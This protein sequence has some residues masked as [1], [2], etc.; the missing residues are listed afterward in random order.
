AD[1][2]SVAL[3]A[4]MRMELA[5]LRRLL[6]SA[7]WEGDVLHGRAGT[8]EVAATV[9]GI[10][11]SLATHATER[12]LGSFDVSHVVVV[13]VAGWV[14]PDLG[15]G[16]LLVPELVIDA[17]SGRTY[18]ASPLGDSVPRGTLSTSDV[19]QVDVADLRQKGVVAVD[20]ETAAVA[21]VCER[22]GCPF[23]AFRAMSD[24]AEGPVDEAVLRLSRQDGTPDLAAVARYVIAR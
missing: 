5:P 10:G 18:R 17:A 15:I 14:G 22:H 11:T 7:R 3:V 2:A 8:T 16:E 20:M 23:T 19:L 4:P 1:P 13:G 24:A 12:L 9:S 6:S 21:A